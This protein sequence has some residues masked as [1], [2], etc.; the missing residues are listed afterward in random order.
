MRGSGP[1]MLT[2]YQRSQNWQYQRNPNYYNADRPFLDSMN[3]ALISDPTVQLAQFRAKRLWWLTPDAN[4]V[5]DV[6]RDPARWAC[7][8]STP[9]P[10]GSTV[11]TR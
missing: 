4:T 9:S 6:K 10:A 2:A 3:F 5:M 8:A 1:W 7:R 11:V